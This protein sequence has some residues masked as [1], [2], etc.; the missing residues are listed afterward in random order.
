MMDKR[1]KLGITPAE[2]CCIVF[3]CIGAIYFVLGIFLLQSLPQ[4]EDYEAG[5]VFTVLGGVFLLTTVIL[6]LFSTAKRRKL[7]RI[8]S[9]GRYLWGQIS[10]V[11]VNQAIRVNGRNP[12][13]VLVRYEDPH[14]NLHLFRSGNLKT[15]PDRSVIGKQ[16]RV[17]YENESYKHYYIDLEGVLPTVI[18]H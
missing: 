10:D 8:V 12:Y 9:E 4:T 18:E 5:M 3:G 14:G 1:I 17:Y 2:L 15:Y 16:V 11:V 13:N 6:L 7:Q